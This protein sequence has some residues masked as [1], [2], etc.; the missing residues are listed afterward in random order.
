MT[1]QI[2]YQI[3]KQGTKGE[4]VFIESNTKKHYQKEYSQWLPIQT[5][6]E[7]REEWKPWSIF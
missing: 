7:Q 5:L 1:E 2:D 3:D 4:Q 6:K